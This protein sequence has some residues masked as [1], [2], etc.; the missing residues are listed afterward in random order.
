MQVALPLPARR[1]QGCEVRASSHLLGHRAYLPVP[2]FTFQL[3]GCCLESTS[4]RSLDVPFFAAGR[5]T[6]P[7]SIA[8]GLLYQKSPFAHP[9]A[10][11]VDH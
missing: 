10:Q 6:V 11:D 2:V 8:Y 3:V 1:S 5:L 7:S 4:L 9:F